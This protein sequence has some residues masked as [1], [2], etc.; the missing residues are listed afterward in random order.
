MP[1][2]PRWSW[3]CAPGIWKRL[4][5]FANY[6]RLRFDNYENFRRPQNLL[7]GGVSFDHRS[8]SLRWNF[9]WVPIFRRN[10]I[11]TNGWIQMEGERLTH[12]MQF[13]YRFSP[14]L[15]F[16][17]NARNIFNRPQRNYWGPMRSDLL[18]RNYDFG[19]IWTV[20][21]RGGF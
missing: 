17:V 18:Y 6:T 19:G 16:F 12:D 4:S 14:R 1:R 2:S 10:A 15:T 8:L 3:N 7:N 13:G 20:G 21:V 9:M 5:L 11:A